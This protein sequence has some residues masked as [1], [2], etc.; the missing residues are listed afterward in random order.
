M[1]KITNE[2]YK[3]Y[4]KL[5]RKQAWKWSWENGFDFDEMLGEG[6]LVFCIC[7][8]QYNNKMRVKFSSF[9]YG[10]LNFR[11]QDLVWGIRK[12]KYNVNTDLMGPV[13][14]RL[15]TTY[16]V[17]DTTEQNHYKKLMS[18][19][20]PECKRLIHIVIHQEPKDLSTLIKHLR[21]SKGWKWSVIDKRIKDVKT[22]IKKEKRHMN[23]DLKKDKGKINETS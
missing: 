20:P 6:N 10:K 14:K 19:I 8:H 3:Q 1:Q 22:I 13:G 12:S 9:L 16:Q 7:Y 15:D 4:E 21:K 2:F 17:P 23:D 18:L 11:Y 5:I